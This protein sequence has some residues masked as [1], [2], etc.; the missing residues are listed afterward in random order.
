MNDRL[1]LA[2]KAGTFY[3]FRDAILSHAKLIRDAVTGEV[4]NPKR[5]RKKIRNSADA[6]EYILSECAGTF[7]KV[8]F[9]FVPVNVN[10]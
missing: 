4:L 7:T 10:K 8:P 6:V 3:F 1:I 5:S 9:T 2:S